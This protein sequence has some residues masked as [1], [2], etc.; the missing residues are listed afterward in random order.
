MKTHFFNF[1]PRFCGSGV[2][3]RRVTLDPNEVTCSACK[4][5][6]TLALTESGRCFTSEE[7]DQ[8]ELNQ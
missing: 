3:G 7:L 4:A 2:K 8:W 5:G 1:D 6:D